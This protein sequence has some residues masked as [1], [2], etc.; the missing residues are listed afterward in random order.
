MLVD[1][2]DRNPAWLIDDRYDTEKTLEAA[3]TQETAERREQED[4]EKKGADKVL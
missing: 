1:Y 3:R 2:V 4:G